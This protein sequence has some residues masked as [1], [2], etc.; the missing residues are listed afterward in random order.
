MNCNDAG[1]VWQWVAFIRCSGVN[2][3][4]LACTSKLD[5]LSLYKKYKNSKLT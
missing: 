1:P 3:S 2:W 4:K 5:T